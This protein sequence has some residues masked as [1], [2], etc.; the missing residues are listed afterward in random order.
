VFGDPGG[1]VVIRIDRAAGSPVWKNDPVNRGSTAADQSVFVGRDPELDAL[2]RAATAARAGTAHIVLVEAPGGMGK[3]ALINRF[4]SGVS[5][6]RVLRASADEAEADLDWGVVDQLVRAATVAATVPAHADHLGAGAAL[7][8]AVTR[9]A[10]KGLLVLVV[11]DAHWADQRSL[12]ALTFAL[13]RLLHDRVLVLI[14][15]R[16]GTALPDGLVRLLSG[17]SGR[18]L[19]LR[20]LDVAALRTLVS[21]LR[22]T[23]IG[24]SV[25]TR[26]VELTG[27][28]PLHVRA[29]L[30]ELDDDSLTRPRD[31][32][33]VPRSLSLITL[34]RLASCRPQGRALLISASVLGNRA[35]L[36]LSC[37]LAG[38]SDAPAATEDALATGL[39][40]GRAVDKDLVE[41][42]HPLVRRAIY[43]DLRPT[44]RTRLHRQ[45]ARL[46]SGDV[47]LRHRIA[48][49]MG[50]D[51]ALAD[52][53]AVRAAEH[54][55]AG[56]VSSAGITLAESARLTP[57]PMVHE[58]RLL[59]AAR[60][61]VLHGDAL[62]ARAIASQ[63]A[64]LP[65]SPQRRF[66]Q[67]YLH[68]L[69][70]R[71]T[72]GE[73]LIRAAWLTLDPSREPD[74]AGQIGAEL[75]HL[76][77]LDGRPDDGVRWAQRG[78]AAVRDDTSRAVGLRSRYMVAL[79]LRGESDR[80]L[81][82]AA[83]LSAPESVE[84]PDH[85]DAQLG[86]GLVRAWT[87]Q[88]QLA[89]ADFAAVFSAL[90][91]RGNHRDA[92]ITQTYLAEVDYRL[93]RWDDSVVESDTA[94]SL[95]VDSEQLWLVPFTR[96]IAVAPL[97][98]R[99]SWADAE[100]HLRQADRVMAASEA[101]NEADIGYVA[102]ARAQLAAARGDSA[103]VV[104]AVG[105]IMALPHGGGMHEPG[106]IPWQELYA[107]A[108]VDLGH[109]EHADEV[110]TALIS[111]AT[112]RGRESALAAAWASRGRLEAARG[113][114]SVARRHFEVAL[115][116]AAHVGSPFRAAQIHL[117][118]GCCLL[119]GGREHQAAGEL[120]AARD[121][122]A[123]LG[124]LPYLHR[125]DEMLAASQQSRPPRPAQPGNGLT[126]QE[127]ATARLVASGLTNREAASELV[128]SVKTIEY[129]LANVYSKL[130]V[131][132]RRD[133]R[134]A[135]ETTS[136]G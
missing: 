85:L 12:Q 61:F 4:L 9:D 86:R 40:D 35:P 127:L 99:G 69:N 125:A 5:D 133:L 135:F 43:D 136:S 59:A 87:D 115:E 82:L 121:G 52:L 81:T 11:E 80:A 30:E 54:L 97:A 95:V 98:A 120:H 131:R 15:S 92:V 126:P 70:G 111:L 129:H 56:A 84:S 66:V 122:F 117:S 113:N 28:N 16:P 33:P 2:A 44:T 51:A 134:R 13:R 67:G 48:A 60:M 58:E 72:S 124:A 25:A 62:R 31:D 75:S 96:A 53:L 7:L 41:F 50:K 76:A 49:T 118:Y 104:A 100:E 45:A 57:D 89:R 18:L 128:V 36:S 119:R 6:A 42:T 105:P 77:F 88:W 90:R 17:G 26:L 109:L 78:Y 37:L 94:A 27:G 65:D 108:L 23:E 91:L 103:A 106:I 114:A 10:G 20:G 101:P 93:G 1:Q 83:D 112:T 3:S 29:I 21:E 46:T 24:L 63:L 68:V 73:R 19:Q 71:R 14:T 32:L 116:R 123:T 55:A 110:I 102:H 22:F 34:S 130:H 39:I 74:L 38:T 64:A 132:N 79:A 107:D 47:S 8:Q